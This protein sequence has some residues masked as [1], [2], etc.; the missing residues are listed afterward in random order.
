MKVIL[1]H[2]SWCGHCRDLLDVIDKYKK[3]LHNKGIRLYKY[4]ST[5]DIKEIKEF[6]K[7]YGFNLEYFPTFLLVEGENYEELPTDF[8]D[9]KKRINEICNKGN[10]ESFNNQ[11]DKNENKKILFSYATFKNPSENKIIR[12]YEELAKVNDFLFSSI[13]DINLQKPFFV[14]SDKGNIQ[15]FY[16]VQSDLKDL[17]TYITNSKKF[18]GN[19]FVPQFLVNLFNPDYK[20]Q[21]QLGN[22]RIV[23]CKYTTDSNGNIHSDCQNIY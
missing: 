18:L 20:T 9:F 10:K 8:E 14:V 23:K 2:A 11:E 4:E 12:K 7:N 1:F 21:E 3:F 15:R 22:N 19:T 6:E 16:F 17:Y 5:E 13:V